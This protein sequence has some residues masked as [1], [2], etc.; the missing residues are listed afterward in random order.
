VALFW[1]LRKKIFIGYGVA[2]ILVIVVFIWAFVNLFELGRASD[3]IL[4][5]NYKS[6]IAAENMIDAIERQDSGVLLLLLGYEDEG[7]EQYRSNESQFL[8]WLG[9]AKDNIT[10]EGESKIISLIDQSYSSYMVSFSQLRMLYHSEEQKGIT[11]YHESVLP[12]FKKVHSECVHLREINEETMFGASDRARIIAKKAMRSMVIISIAAVGIGLGFSLFLSNLLVKP[13]QQMKKA[14]QK[15]AEGSYNVQISTGSSDELGLLAGEFNT[16]AKKLKEYHDLNIKQIVIEKGKSEAIIQNIDDGILV[17][18]SDFKITSMNPT[19]AEALGVDAEKAKE[20]HFLEVIKAEQ[21]FNYLK[22]SAETGR[23]P[24]IEEGKN[25]FTIQQGEKIRHYQFSI[26][27]IHAND[28]SMLGVVLLLRDITRLKELDQ[29]KSEFVMAASHELR[30]PLT[31]MEMSIELLQESATEKLSKKER[32]LL[33][34]A[35]E[36][37]HRLK[38]LVLDLLDLSKIE[39]GKMELLFDKISVKMLFEKIYTVF[40]SQT[41]EKSIKLTFKAP[42]DLP[43]IKADANKITWVLSNLISNAL[44]YTNKGG[45]IHFFAE[46]IGSQ[47]HISVKDDGVGIPYEYQS[48]IFEKFVQVKDD[49]SVGGSGLGLTICKEIVR[50]HG[51]TIWAE[52]IPGEGSTFTFTLPVAS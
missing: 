39:A 48:K 46:H 26:T 50:A 1:T 28:S 13:L 23:P 35:D 3:D 25:I 4:S 20:K 43:E 29:L 44:R 51:G 14:T 7:L 33:L 41:D 36:E 22:Q 21:L 16:M 52:S 34:A 47:I 15:L 12:A 6:I 27:P 37:L 38:A 45:H 17:V 2:I 49:R 31:S 24:S 18:D 8:Q 5:E 30:T 10:I 40:K 11:F 19:M 9:R 32:Q 42:G